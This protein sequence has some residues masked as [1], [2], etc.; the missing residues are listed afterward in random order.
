MITHEEDVAEHADRR[1][2]LGDG[3]LHDHDSAEAHL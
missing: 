3:R 1:L 2:V